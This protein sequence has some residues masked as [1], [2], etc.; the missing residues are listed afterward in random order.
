MKDSIEI[1]GVWYD[2]RPAPQ[3]PDLK[4]GDIVK[5]NRGF[6]GLNYRVGQRGIIIAVH[7]Y[8]HLPTQYTVEYGSHRARTVNMPRSLTLVPE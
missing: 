8:T 2:R 7:S 6:S 5:I 3:P 1:D 4:V